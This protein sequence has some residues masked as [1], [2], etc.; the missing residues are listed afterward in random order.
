MYFSV[1]GSAAHFFNGGTMMKYSDEYLGIKKTATI[2]T[3]AEIILKSKDCMDV[4]LENVI[5][6]K[7]NSIIEA[8]EKVLSSGKTDK[9]IVQEI[10]EII[11]KCKSK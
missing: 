3:I 5:N 11:D 7:A 9:E 6:I 4:S 2:E 10:R 1:R 8:I